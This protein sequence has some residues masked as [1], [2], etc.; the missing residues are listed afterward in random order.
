MK[1]N[2]APHSAINA[3]DPGKALRTLRN[4]RGWTLLELSQLTGLPLSTLSKVER[5]KM[6]LNYEKMVRIA[7]S[8][9][10][11]IGVLFAAG[12]SPTSS[13]APPTSGRRSV[14]RSGDGHRIETETAIQHY[15]A[16]DLLRKQLVPLFMELKAKTRAEL[17]D[18]ISHPGEEFVAVLEG[19]MELWTEFYAPV[20]L[21][22]GDSIYFDSM[23]AHGYVSVSE[24][25]CKILSVNATVGWGIDFSAERDDD[26][27]Q[28]ERVRLISS[29]T[30]P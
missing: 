14:T 8:L 11:D 21:E 23:M 3:I 6:S 16:A 26:I 28:S 12:P 29:R 7:T 25:P 9:N 15:P 30:K 17:G 27:A 24:E 2:R 13:V 4:E 10:I 22:K 18:L 19:A 5:N 1:I 20:R